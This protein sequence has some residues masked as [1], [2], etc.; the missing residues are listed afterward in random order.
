MFSRFIY[1]QVQEFGSI[2]Q[3]VE[4]YKFARKMKIQSLTE[5]LDRKFRNEANA[6]QVFEIVDLYMEPRNQNGLDWAK[7]VI[8]ETS[9]SNNLL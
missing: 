1:G 5:I 6:S 9:W 7:R 2:S 4:V 3:C 8:I